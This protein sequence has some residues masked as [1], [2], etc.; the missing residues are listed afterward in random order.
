MKKVRQATVKKVLTKKFLEFDNLVSS[1]QEFFSILKPIA[2]ERVS[3]TVGN[4]CVRN[5]I[6]EQMKSYGWHVDV[7]HFKEQTPFG[8]KSFANITA[9]YPIGVHFAHKSVQ[10]LQKS[11]FLL[12]NRIVFAC[13]Y[14]SKYFENFK[15]IGATDSAVPCA[16]LLD[17]AKF[18]SENFETKNFDKLTRHIQFVF[19]DGEEAFKTWSKSDSIYGSRHYAN[20]LKK[21]YQ[22]EAFDSIDL[23]VLLDLIG[24]DNCQFANLFPRSTSDCYAL[25]AGIETLLRSKRLL[26][27]TK[28]YY[29]CG[30][31][32][33][34]GVDDD[35]TPF[36]NEN[37]PVLQLIPSPFPTQWHNSKDT[38]ENLNKS[39][40]QDM[41]V[42]LKCFMLEL[43]SS[44]KK[45]AKF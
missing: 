22:Q 11:D 10:S 4:A 5:Y 29:F 21:Q 12:E 16:L 23:F 15:F 44:E 6:M 19:F 2:I 7:D 27:K 3:D 33:F 39:N 45:P 43:L 42:I 18:L 1:Y 9:S 13:H 31:Y 24:A 17:V 34:F 38:V 32:A 30:Q 8:Y 20:T 40:I 14:D 37:V 36:L 25:L 28:Q 26:K 41:R 35:H